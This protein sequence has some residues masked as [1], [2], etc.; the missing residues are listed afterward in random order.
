MERVIEGSSTACPALRCIRNSADE[1]AFVWGANVSTW[2]GLCF[3]RS[4]AI[5]AAEKAELEDQFAGRPRQARM[6][7]G[8]IT[9]AKPLVSGWRRCAGTT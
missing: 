2:S 5:A 9:L 6:F 7:G 8:A 3:D 4:G 1:V